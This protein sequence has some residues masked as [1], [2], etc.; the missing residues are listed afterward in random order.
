MERQL[1]QS[2]RGTTDLVESECRRALE[3]LVLGA[4]LEDALD[5]LVRAAQVRAGGGAHAAVFIPARDDTG[6][7]VG[8]ASDPSFVHVGVDARS[9]SD[10]A[11]Q[12]RR[13]AALAGEPIIV[14]DVT[15]DPRSQDL[16]DRADQSGIRAC[17]SYP[18]ATSRGEVTGSLEVYPVR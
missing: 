2:R 12:T 13:R 6:C 9:S 5:V 17:W 7:A 18:I 15:T 14:S 4:P 8:A 11:S 16:A 1:P 3:T 10:P